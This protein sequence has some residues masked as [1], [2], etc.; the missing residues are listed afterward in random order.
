MAT[1]TTLS[2]GARGRITLPA[3]LRRQHGIEG[4]M[5]LVLW[6]TD[7]AIALMTRDQLRRRVS[8]GLTYSNLVDELLATRR[9][10]AADEDRA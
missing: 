5:P 2:V 10:D 3:A 1:V 4:G 6:D 8:N 9:R 7:E